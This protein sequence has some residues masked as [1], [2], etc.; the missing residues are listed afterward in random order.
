MNLVIQK[1][2]NSNMITLPK[3]L[4]KKLGWK[5]GD[6]VKIQKTKHNQVLVESK[7]NHQ[8]EFVGQIEIP[9]FDFDKTQADI[10]TSAYKRNEI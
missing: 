1:I 3:P 7:Q 10:K 2:G 9:N 5:T 8:D 6:Y 4:M